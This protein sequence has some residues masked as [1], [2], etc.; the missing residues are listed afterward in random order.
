MTLT[1][2]GRLQ[3]RLIL[4]VLGALPWALLAAPLFSISRVAAAAMIALTTLL[5]LLWELGYH[6]L[7][8]RRPDRDWPSLLALLAGLP[9]YALLH[10]ATG[11][12]GLTPTGHPGWFFLSTWI[13][14][15]LAQQ[16][17]LRVIAPRWRF[18]GGRL[19]PKNT[20]PGNQT[21]AKPGNR[22]ARHT[23]HVQRKPSP[24]TWGPSPVS[25]SIQ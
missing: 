7:Q 18:T 3:T 16:G 22:A 8:Q 19:A 10:L 2:T 1:L 4:A 6:A 14:L 13:L 23:K 24:T 5:G 11:W 20:S 15:W 9:E 25:Q 12:A 17:P 21:T